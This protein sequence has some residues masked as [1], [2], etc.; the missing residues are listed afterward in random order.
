MSDEDKENARKLGA[1]GF[2][3]KPQ[4]YREYT[5]QVKTAVNFFMN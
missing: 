5:E 4:D 3:S 2:I 1:A